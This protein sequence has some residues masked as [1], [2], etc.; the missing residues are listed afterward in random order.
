MNNKVPI[1]EEIHSD[2]LQIALIIR[3]EYQCKE[4]SINFFTPNSFSQQIGVMKR[5]KGYKIDPHIHKRVKREVLFT[6]EVLLIKYGI[7]KVDFYNNE[8]K[9]L[10]SR[11]LKAGDILLLI[12]G[13][14]G[15]TIIEEAEI[16]EIKQGPYVGDL[17][18]LRF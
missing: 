5:P 18:K 13:G 17:D 4:N 7:V 6:N 11:T 2:S 14:H 9:Y 10:E 15:F 12:R 3:N 1:I 16:F 8:K